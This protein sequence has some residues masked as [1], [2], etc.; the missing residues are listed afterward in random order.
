MHTQ[1]DPGCGVVQDELGGGGGG[2][3]GVVVPPPPAS[4][5]GWSGGS[6]LP[7]MQTQ[8]GTGCA[9]VQ[10]EL[11]GGG[12]GGVVVPPP[13]DP[14]GSQFPFTQTQSDAGCTV[15][16]P[17]EGGGGDEPPPDGSAPPL[18]INCPMI[19]LKFSEA[20]AY[21]RGATVLAATLGCTDSCVP[22]DVTWNCE[23]GTPL[24]PISTPQ[25]SALF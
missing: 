21:H 9:V 7:L 16:H 13:P 5:S 8:P 19:C 14:G 24:G 18:P 15:V 20:T 1:S 4:T 12:G 17:D 6:Q 10:D 23:P 22:E 25:T 2:G 3:G 11:G